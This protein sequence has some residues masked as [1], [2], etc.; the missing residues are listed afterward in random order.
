MP[1]TGT[2]PQAIIALNRFGLGK[3][4]NEQLPPDP[5]AWLD[6]QIEKYDPAPQTLAE[7]E[8]TRDIAVVYMTARKGLVGAD[9]ETKVQ[10]RKAL[11]KENGQRYRKEVDRRI[12]TALIT[13]TPFT[14]RLVYFWSNHFAVSANKPQVTALAGAFEREA[15]RPHIMGRFTNLLMAA[16]QHPAMLFF[17]D[18]V[19]SAGPNSRLA[20]NVAKQNGKRKP[21]I[22]ENLARESMELHTVGVKGGYTQKDVT[23]LALALTGW[24]TGAMGPRGDTDNVGRYV[25]RRAMHEPGTRTIMGKPYDQQNDDQAIAVLTDLASLKPTARHIA[26]KLCRH[27]ISDEPPAPVVERVS[28]VFLTSGGDLPSVYRAL[29]SAPESWALPPSK[30]KTPWEWLISSLRALGYN[31]VDTIK[32]AGLLNQSGQPTWRPGSPA[33]YDDTVASWLAPDALMKRVDVAQ[34]L[35][36]KTAITV[37]PQELA[38]DLL[39]SGLEVNTRQQLTRAESIQ[40]GYALLLASPAFQRR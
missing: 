27:F 25:F 37:K 22:N 3:R 33:G 31:D 4:F 34:Q 28:D 17:L 12:L 30:L 9:S 36:A 6:N 18:Q 35:S 24:S 16:E 19:R 7:S 2:T 15:I 11:R 14:E 8:T 23:E 39:G 38:A 40:S 21:G 29:M 13:P 20:L 5:M 1:S 32:V 26:F 10:L